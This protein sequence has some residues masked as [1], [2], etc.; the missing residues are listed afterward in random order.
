MKHLPDDVDFVVRRTLRQVTPEEM[1]RRERH[2]RTERN[3]ETATAAVCD[4]ARKWVARP[5]SENSTA[6]RSAV[7][8]YDAAE[9]AWDV[10]HAGE[11]AEEAL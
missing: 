9:A 10:A 3:L 7:R 6:L 2:D 8:V 11:P 4:A 5:T 1:L